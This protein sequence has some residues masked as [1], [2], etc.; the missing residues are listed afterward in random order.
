MNAIETILGAKPENMWR[1]ESVANGE[2]NVIAYRAT[3]EECV[4]AQNKC[5]EGMMRDGWGLRCHNYQWSAII[6]NDDLVITERVDFRI[7]A[8]VSVQAP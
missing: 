2:P 8:P 3:K 5:M 6:M 1:L 4:D 7:V